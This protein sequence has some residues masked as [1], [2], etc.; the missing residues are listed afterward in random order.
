[1]SKAR[2]IYQKLSGCDLIR[3]Q[4]NA[5]TKH[6]LPVPR[7]GSAT[8]STELTQ[9]RLDKGNKIPANTSGVSSRGSF[10]KSFIHNNVLHEFTESV[11]QTSVS[12]GQVTGSRQIAGKSFM[13]FDLSKG[14]H[15]IGFRNLD[16]E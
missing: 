15:Y 9:M 7:V 12:G 5:L 13:K 2:T 14:G 16:D 11:H 4:V 8:N 6:L 3:A 1:M 10:K